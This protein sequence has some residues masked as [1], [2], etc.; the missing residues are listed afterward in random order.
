MDKK[1]TTNNGGIT[2]EQ[3]ATFKAKHNKV[4]EISV[5]DDDTVHI[6]YFKRPDMKTMS[7]V[8]TIGKKDEVESGVVM[9]NNCWLGGSSE[10]ESDA[11][12]KMAAIGQ[13][14]S[15]F[16]TCVGSLKNL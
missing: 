9:F 8:N 5:Q 10:M 12:V 14:A 15:V 7:A 13:L 3:I 4:F 16:N 1:I 6:G 11:I 2:D